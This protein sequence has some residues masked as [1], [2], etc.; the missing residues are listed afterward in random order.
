MRIILQG[1]DQ[2]RIHERIAVLRRAFIEKFD[3]SHFNVTTIDFAEA[4]VQDLHTALNQSGLFTKKQLV[5]VYGLDKLSETELAAVVQ[6]FNQM[7]ADAIAVIVVPALNDLPTAPAKLLAV[8][9]KIESFP[10]LTPTEVTQWL[11]RHLAV[12]Q[13]SVDPAVV[14]YLVQAYG[15]DLWSLQSVVTQLQHAAA[16]ISLELVQQYVVSPL[17]EN[18][19]HLSD[20]L[21]A[22]QTRRA[23]QLLHD[24]L[25]GGA[26]AFYLL[27]MLARQIE[28]LLQ[29]KQGTFAASV[30]P[31]ARKKASEHAKRF[32]SAA[33]QQLHTGLTEI[34]YQMKTTTLDPTVLLDRWVVEAT[35]RQPA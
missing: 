18:I 5:V 28:L 25:Q 4:T 34:D 6:R 31:Y 14:P 12:T 22:Q 26:N 15:N 29:A 30:A 2:F 11:R 20:A 1:N 19:F 7:T 13:R 32:S 10:E 3:P 23:I 9:S 24:Q 33:L 21:A 16:D 35:S 17:D 27:T 8:D